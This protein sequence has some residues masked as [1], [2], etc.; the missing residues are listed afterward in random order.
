MVVPRTRGH[1]ASL[2]ALY[3]TSSSGYFATVPGVSNPAGGKSYTSCA[4]NSAG[5][6][7]L[8]SVMLRAPMASDI[9]LELAVCENTKASRSAGSSICVPKG[10]IIAAT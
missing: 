5:D 7:L 6:T 10:A 2:L 9:A 3:N 8:I 1:M 4:M